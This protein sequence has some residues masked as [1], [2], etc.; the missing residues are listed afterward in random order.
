LTFL[1]ENYEVVNISERGVQFICK[2]HHEFKPDLEMQFSITFRDND[3]LELEGKILRVEG[4]VTVIYLSGNIPFSRIV[5]E[6]RYIK[7][8]Y[9]DY[10]KK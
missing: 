8:N 5:Q 7:D 9:P 4:K 3:P 10:F 6:Q 2:K 1:G